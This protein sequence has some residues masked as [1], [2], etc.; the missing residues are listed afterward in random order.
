MLIKPAHEFG[1]TLLSHCQGS[2]AC[3]AFKCFETELHGSN[4]Y[5]IISLF[6]P[7]RRS[8]WQP[9]RKRYVG[10][11]NSFSVKQ[12][13][14]QQLGPPCYGSEHSPNQVKQ[15]RSL[16]FDKLIYLWKSIFHKKGYLMHKK[17]NCLGGLE[18]I[19]SSFF[20]MESKDKISSQDKMFSH[21]WNHRT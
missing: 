1:C 2:S 4:L 11:C 19:K 5:S 14:Y 21:C 7:P 20:T 8:I 15:M 13:I 9:R 6:V 17:L 3:R 18:W 10:F 12:H 16:Y